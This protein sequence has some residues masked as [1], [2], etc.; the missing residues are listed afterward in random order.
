MNESIISDITTVPSLSS[1]EMSPQVNELFSALSKFQSAGIIP[2]K[3]TKGNFSAYASK[4]DIFE[5]VFEELG[6]NGLSYS[7]HPIRQD[8]E[9]SSLLTI[10]AHSSGQWMKSIFTLVVDPNNRN[11]QHGLGGAIT[12]FSRYCMSNI[13]GIVSDNDDVEGISNPTSTDMNQENKPE[14]HT[15]DNNYYQD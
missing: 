13:L 15:A 11:K 3:K 14:E 10:V 6:K 1:F 8:D 12:Y 9:T 7:Q 5:S 4:V 2:A